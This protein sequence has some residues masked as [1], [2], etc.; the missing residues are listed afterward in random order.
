M[1]KP[2]H[3]AVTRPVK[4]GCEEEFEKAVLDFFAQTLS[5]KG[6]LGA[7][8]LKPLPGSKDQTYGILRSFASKEACDHFYKSEEYLQWQSAVQPLVDKTYSRQK[9]QGLEAFFN[10]HLADAKPAEWK[11]ALL[12][13]IGVWPTVYAV[14]NLVSQKLLTSWPMWWGMGA[15]TLIVVILLTWVVMPI[16]TKLF[17]GWLIPPR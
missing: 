9:L 5:Q 10:T 17:Q 16:L 13:W 3:I 1:E 6:S 11:M 7:Q 14:T 15:D 2:I 8:L 12:T 4:P